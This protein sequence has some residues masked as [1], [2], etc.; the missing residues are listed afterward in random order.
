[1]LVL[2]HNVSHSGVIIIGD[3][4]WN[5]EIVGRLKEEYIKMFFF[6]EGIKFSKVGLRLNF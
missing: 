5:R 1:M 6:L 3:P 4:E 2:R